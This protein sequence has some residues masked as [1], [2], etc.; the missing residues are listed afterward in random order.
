MLNF[1]SYSYSHQVII[2]I[3]MLLLRTLGRLASIEATTSA[4][5]ASTIASQQHQNNNSN[6]QL[7]TIKDSCLQRLK[8]ILTKPQEEYLRIHVETGGCSGF[9][10]MFEIEDKNIDPKEDLV[11]ERE[12]Y[13]VVINKDILPYMK[14]AAIEFDDSLMKSSFSIKNPIAET[15]CSCGT[16]FSV[17]FNKIDKQ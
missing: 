15:K 6:S 12:T 9:S 10:Y 16:S 17:D 5:F 7:F 13:K 4:R 8:Q 2:I 3:G 14:G 11:F 1:H